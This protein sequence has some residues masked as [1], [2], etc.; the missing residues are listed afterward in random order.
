MATVWFF[1]AWRYDKRLWGFWSGVWTLLQVR[2]RET[3][4][5]LEKNIS[6][7]DISFSNIVH[8]VYDASWRLPEKSGQFIS[9]ILIQLYKHVILSFHV[10]EMNDNFNNNVLAP[11]CFYVLFISPRIINSYLDLKILNQH[12]VHKATV[13]NTLTKF[14]CIVS[15]WL[16]VF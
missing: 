4:S 5:S 3:M 2:N 9:T 11:F 12:E 6:V 10:F 1:L 14:V 7:L 13:R 15:V 8:L 16:P